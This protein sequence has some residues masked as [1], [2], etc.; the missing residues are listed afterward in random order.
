MTVAWPLYDLRVRTPRLTLRLPTETE[1]MDLGRRAVGRVLPPERAAFMGG[2]TQLP[3][4]EFERSLLQF[5][6]GLRASWSP[7]AWWLE[8]AV[9]EAGSEGPVGMAGA[10]TS[11][12]S[13]TR[14]AN[15]GSWLLPEARGRGLGKETR[16][17][18]IHLLFEGLGAVEVRSNAHPENDSSNGVSRSLGYREDGTD[19]R[20]LG[21][22]E[23][24]S[25]TRFVLRREEWLASRR[26]DVEIVGLEGCRSM[27]EGGV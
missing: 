18:L 17:A 24:V 4:P 21:E 5:N 16:R 26:D 6:W 25:V 12:F 7:A 1:L 22:G 9:F 11:G 14:S 27:F 3:S 19:V 10:H 8:L 2:W 13:R 20:I 15:T 23:A